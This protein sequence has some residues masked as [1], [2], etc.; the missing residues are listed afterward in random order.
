MTLYGEHHARQKKSGVRDFKV[1]GNFFL[2]GAIFF[3]QNLQ[4]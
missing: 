3:V 4:L 2:G 1:A